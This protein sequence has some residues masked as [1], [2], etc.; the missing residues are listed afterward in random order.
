MSRTFWHAL[1]LCCAYDCFRLR[2]PPDLSLALTPLRPGDSLRAVS[3][4]PKPPE[5][6]TSILVFD[7]SHKQ[8]RRDAVATEEPLEIRLRSTGVKE[9]VIP[10]V[11]RRAQANGER[12]IAITMR[13]PGSDLELAA[14]FLYGEGVV[15]RRSDILSLARPEDIELEDTKRQN[16]VIVELSSGV[17][18]DF[19]A[20]ERHFYTTS[21]CGVCGKTSLESLKIQGA[22]RISAG[23]PVPP[24]VLYSLPEKLQAQQS[25][26]ARTGGLHAS[27]LFDGEGRL[28]A[29]REDVGRHNALDKLIGWA[30]LEDRLPLSGHIVM[31]SGR[32]SFEILQKCLMAGV[33]IVC[34]VSAP[35]SLA[36]DVARE[37]GITLVGFLRGHHYNIYANPERIEA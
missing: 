3:T 25:V 10:V 34:A 19:Q 12:T 30:L 27:A 9:G 36:V 28:I 6:T 32:S 35:S 8:P 21:A 15:R 13:T 5:A 1:N 26:F 4:Q 29:V 11:S 7:P 2:R 22:P 24:D 14:G 23:P 37:F 31:V 18:P 33:P 16:I 17:I 20:L